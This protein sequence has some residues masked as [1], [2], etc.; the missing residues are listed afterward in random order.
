VIGSDGH[1]IFADTGVD[2]RHRTD[3]TDV[4][5]VLEKRPVAE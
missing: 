2:Y 4:L 3:P 1:I 5:A